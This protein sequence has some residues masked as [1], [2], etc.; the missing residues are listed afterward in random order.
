M[1]GAPI[2]NHQKTRP[3]SVSPCPGIEIYGGLSPFFG[4][5]ATASSQERTKDTKAAWTKRA[6]NAEV[7]KRRYAWGLRAAGVEDMPDAVA[8]WVVLISAI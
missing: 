4:P 3:A 2:G 7:M 6:C 8:G 1:P 5:K